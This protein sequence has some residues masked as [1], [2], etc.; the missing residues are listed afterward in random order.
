MAEYKIPDEIRN[1]NRF[2]L[3]IKPFEVEGIPLQVLEE[4]ESVLK[5]QRRGISRFQEMN[6]GQGTLFK[7]EENSLIGESYEIKRIKD[8][9]FRL[10]PS[11]A[12][13]LIQAETGCGKEL[14]AKGIQRHSLRCNK[15][16]IKVNC[17]AFPESLFESELFGYVEGA[18]TG[19]LKRG[20]KGLFEAANGGTIFLDEIGE[21]P[22]S[23]QAKLLRVLQEQEITRIGGTEAIPI[24]VRIISATNQNLRTLANTGKFRKDLYF[25]LNVIPVFINPLRER[26]E[27]IP[28]LANHF[29]QKYSKKYDIPKILMDDAMEALLNYDWPGNVRE[30]ENLIERLFAWGTGERVDRTELQMATI[31]DMKDPMVWY[32]KEVLSLEEQVAIVEKQ[33]ITLALYNYGTTRKAARHLGISQPTLCRKI[34]KYNIRVDTPY[35]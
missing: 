8:F 35:T 21:L 29:L 5:I 3:G 6:K 34:Q 22:M 28:V 15:P 12:S 1:H 20:K 2:L 16:F 23:M 10:Q 33:A 4:Y 17:S 25:R 18:F 11:D 9:F 26:K 31:D 27:D 13:V 14:I 30:L 24:D 19:A 32:D 7:A